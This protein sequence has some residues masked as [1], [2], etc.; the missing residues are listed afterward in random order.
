MDDQQIAAGIRAKDAEAFRELVERHGPGLYSFLVYRL[1]DRT[2]ADDAYAEVMM[3]IWQNAE[4]YQ[5]S[6]RLKAWLYTIAHRTALDRLRKKSDPALTEAL[7]DRAISA[8]PGPEREA[9]SRQ[10]SQRFR[11]AL[12]DLPEAQREVFLMREYSGL[13][14]AEIAA[15]L[16]CPLGTALAR[17][18]YAVLK[19][20]KG[21][22][23]FHA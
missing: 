22:E 20:R 7:E 13:S 17:M 15:A 12:A 10:V 18:R 19:L 16:G 14:F 11:E 2:E 6:G 21:L 5:E 1:G 9:E 4:R 23:E 8:E 3:K